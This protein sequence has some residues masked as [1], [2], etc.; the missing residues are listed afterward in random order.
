M[1]GY[2]EMFYLTENFLSLPL[3]EFLQSEIIQKLSLLRKKAL[4]AGLCMCHSIT[5]VSFCLSP[6]L[7]LSLSVFVSF[8]PSVSVSLFLSVCLSLFLSLPLSLP[9][10]LAL[11]IFSKM[12]GMMDGTLLFASLRPTAYGNRFATHP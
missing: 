12:Q 2:I 4:G 8:S 1:L 10:S 11:S 6:F 9:L 7:S 3:N 5:S